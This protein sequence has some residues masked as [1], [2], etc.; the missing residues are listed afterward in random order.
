MKKFLLASSCLLLIFLTG[1]N[2]GKKLE[3]IQGGETNT[4]TVKDN[5]IIK[6]SINDEEE[7]ISEEEWETLKNF[8]EFDDDIT[9]DEIIN[10]I[11][12]LNEG[13]GYT[14]TIK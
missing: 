1:C 9:T 6:N 2:N 11:K 3:C 5:K 14:C 4:I 10:K 7:T 12:E 8:Y 13:F